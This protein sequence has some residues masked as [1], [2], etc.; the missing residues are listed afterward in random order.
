MILENNF[1]N[2]KHKLR[3]INKIKTYNTSRKQHNSSLKIKKKRLAICYQNNY[4][5]NN[6]NQYIKKNK[7]KFK[8][9]K[10]IN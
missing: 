1:N 9:W 10:A 5:S 6:S 7:N 3:L 4:K 8:I 2:W